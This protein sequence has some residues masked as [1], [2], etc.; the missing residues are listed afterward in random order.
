LDVIQ[1][2]GPLRIS[3]FQ[4]GLNPTTPK[5]SFVLYWPISAIV[6]QSPPCHGL[7]V[8]KEKQNTKNEMSQGQTIFI[9]N[10]LFKTNW[11]LGPPNDGNVTIIEKGPS[12]LVTICIYCAVCV[13]SALFKDHDQNLEKLRPKN[14]D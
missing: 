2:R 12:S 6:P 7:P 8:C 11:F 5:I 1:S 13:H 10:S 3:S 14:Q 9:V 4:L